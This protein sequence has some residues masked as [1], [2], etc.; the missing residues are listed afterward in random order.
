MISPLSK[1]TEP[2]SLRAFEKF[3]T[4]EMV[5][6]LKDNTAYDNFRQMTNM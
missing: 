6:I 1:V 2:D 3:I 5:E 4:P